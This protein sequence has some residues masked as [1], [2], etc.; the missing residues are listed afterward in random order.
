MKLSIISQAKPYYYTQAIIWE[1]DGKVYR[2]LYLLIS[3]GLWRDSIDDYS[4]LHIL[5]SNYKSIA[6]Y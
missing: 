6:R 4:I 1:L 5:I 2:E 3:A